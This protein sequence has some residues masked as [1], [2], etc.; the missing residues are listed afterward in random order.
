MSDTNEMSVSP[1]ASG[2]KVYLCGPINGCTD[3][4]ATTWREWFKA[5]VTRVAFVDPMVRD[6][7][8][9]EID[10]YREIVDLDKRDIRGCGVVVVMYVKPSVGTSMEV[11]FAWT[12]GIPVVVID[13]SGK[14]L[15]PWMR[16]HASAVVASKLEAAVKVAEWIS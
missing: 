13:E 7:R 4:E 14:P 9:R 10:D 11:L 3:D 12:L 5:N 15:S 6:Y 16:Y 1:R 8:G 2:C